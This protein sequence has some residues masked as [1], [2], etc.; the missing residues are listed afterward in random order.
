MM[1]RF[2]FGLL[3][4]GSTFSPLIC[5]EES[6][7]D[8]VKED[9]EKFWESLELCLNEAGKH[10]AEAGHLLGL[11]TG[12]SLEK[13]DG[14]L[15][16]IMLAHYSSENVIYGIDVIL[17]QESPEDCDR[18]VGMVPQGLVELIPNPFDEAGVGVFGRG[19][20]GFTLSTRG[21]CELLRDGL[22]CFRSHIG[23]KGKLLWKAR[24]FVD[25][26][27]CPCRA[28]DS[29]GNAVCSVGKFF[30]W[31]MLDDKEDIEPLCI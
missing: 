6:G 4:L 14:C 15:S 25:F 17:A 22:K 13:M 3:L 12:I 19:F 23:R 11:G 24:C 28:I 26:C 18:L 9:G 10:G 7:E 21:K 16:E 1:K 2:L 31:L 20:R 5:M 29:F 30:W 27:M 8:C